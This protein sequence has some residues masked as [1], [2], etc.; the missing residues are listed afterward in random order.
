M[1]IVTTIIFL[2]LIARYNFDVNRVIAVADAMV[3][4]IVTAFVSGCI[5]VVGIVITLFANGNEEFE[6]ESLGVEVLLLKFAGFV[7]AT[8]GLLFY[9]EVIFQKQSK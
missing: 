7:I 3:F 1:L 5:W 8:V 6:I 9:N 4:Q 2:V